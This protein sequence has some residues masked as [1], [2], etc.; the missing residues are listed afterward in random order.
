[1][2]RSRFRALVVLLLVAALAAGS[3]VVARAAEISL[4][5]VNVV[6]PPAAE[7]WEPTS[8]AAPRGARAA[9]RPRVPRDRVERRGAGRGPRPRRV[10]LSGELRGLPRGEG[11]RPGHGRPPLPP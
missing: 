2:S 6:S 9:R 5:V 7:L 1:M 11:R 8:V 10:R 4:T 3:V